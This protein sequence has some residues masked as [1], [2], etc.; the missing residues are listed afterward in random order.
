MMYTAPVF[1]AVTNPVM[2][3]SATASSSELQVTFTP[4]TGLPLASSPCTASCKVS[5]T[6]KS[7]DATGVTSNPASS[8]RTMTDASPVASPDLAVML[9]LPLRTAVT[10][11]DAST[12]ATVPSS[13]DQRNPAFAIAFPLESN[14]SADMRAV[15]P[16]DDRVTLPGE[17]LTWAACC[18]TVTDAVPEAAPAVAVMEALPSR[19]AVTTPLAPTVATPPSLLAQ[20]TETPLI[21][22]PL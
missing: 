17:T 5:P 14:A 22:W 13:V 8:T 4:G 16:T 12:D 20:V 9:A 15:S 6:E 10:S 21:A 18:D 7:V 1:N 3:T 19:T 2:S 11:P